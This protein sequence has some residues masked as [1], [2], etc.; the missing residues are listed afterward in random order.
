MS[1][2]SHVKLF[3]SLIVALFL[4]TLSGVKPAAAAPDAICTSLSTGTWNT[5]ARWS[6]G[7]VPVAADDVII[8]AGH[9]V[10][11]N[12]SPVTILSL[13]VNGT[14]NM[15]ATA[16]TSRTM[17]VSG[18][19]TIN[20][21]GTITLSDV[22]GANTHTLNIGGNFV[23]NGSYTAINGD[24]T[25]VVFNGA[26]NQTVSGT[27][28][29]NNFNR[30]TV[31]NTGAAD[32]N[33]V[34][35]T[36]TN[37]TAGTD[38]LT[39]TD[40]IL[41]LSSSFTLSNDFF[42]AAGY[43][44]P[45]AAGLWLN[46]PNVTVTAQNTDI[47]LNGLL[48]ITAGTYNI[49][50]GGD[51]DLRYNSGAV[52]IMEGGALNIDGKFRGDI[53][54]TDTITF[55]MSGGTLTAPVDANDENSV[56]S[57]DIGNASS[58]FTMSG[59]TIII[60]E[61]STAGTPLD[62]LNV[63]GTINITGGTV[64][65]GDNGSPASETYVVGGIAGT[66]N[67]PNVVLNQTNPP[68]VTLNR[69]ANITGS[70]TI[71]T[72]STFNAGGQ[73]LGISGNWT[74]NG[75]FTSGTQTTIFNGTAAQTIS[76][77]SVTGFST[78]V[79]NSGATVIVPDTNIPTATVAVSNNGTLQ[80]TRAVGPSSNVSF[81]TISTDRYRGVD[82]ST[83]AGV[84]LG[85]VTVTVRGN[86]GLTCPNAGGAA[87]VYVLRCFDITVTTQGAA[88]VTLW[89]TTAEQNG[90]LTSN[91]TPF[92]FSGTWDKLTNVSN[93]TGS[94]NYIFATGDTPGFSSFLLGDDNFSPTAITLEQ[95]G[96]IQGT[97]WLWVALTG[98]L[99]LVS[100]AWWVKK[101]NSQQ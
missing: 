2:Q 30:I 35:I 74:N 21:A 73:A 36:S 16:F 95:V 12:T 8:A 88:A 14:L 84:D 86:S 28:A 38:F 9:T 60:A 32:N 87:P 82:I 37:F 52:F 24:V 49:G 79:V 1:R 97:S 10:T 56:A 22:T 5:V 72:G 58:S 69:P 101:V 90:I 4:W 41:K 98:L 62:Y 31:N 39:L 100:A 34:E 63:A 20:S 43:T 53:P 76:G 77:S 17:T 93:G 67:L 29:T 59:G 50:T 94:N 33:I 96:V 75:T 47:I 51:D 15:N 78:W 55:S 48:R 27:G 7:H 6:C 80:Q 45:A 61:E 57:F 11:L 99:L 23:N 26:S 18:A 85:N 65:F 42:S 40:G 71:N 91:L 13:T 92:R 64:Q 3:L 68:T 54:N 83:G 46:N 25:N 81:L 66:T 44:I 89:A 70:L 19:V